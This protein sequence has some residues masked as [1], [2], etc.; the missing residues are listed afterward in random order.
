VWEVLVDYIFRD[1]FGTE[2]K[3]SEEIKSGILGLLFGEGE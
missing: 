3:S 1:D 2:S